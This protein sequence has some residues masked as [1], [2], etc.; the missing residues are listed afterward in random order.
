[1]FL[2]YDQSKNFFSKHTSSL[3]VQYEKDYLTLNSDHF[4]DK[5]YLSFNQKEVIINFQNKSDIFKYPFNLNDLKE[6]IFYRISNYKI[7]H[8]E[9]DYYPIQQKIENKISSCKL[10]Y[11][12]SLILSNLFLFN[13]GISKDNL[14]K[15]IWPNDKEVSINKIDTHLTNIKNILKKKINFEL[16]VSSKNGLLKLIID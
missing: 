6:K 3:I 4:F 8:I 5:I 7:R 10:T 11:T 1:M 13:Q 14:Y 9:I 16:K 12:H 2:V 15:K